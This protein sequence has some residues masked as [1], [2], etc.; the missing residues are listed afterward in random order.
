MEMLGLCN[1]LCGS[2]ELVETRYFAKDHDNPRRRG[3]RI[4]AF[5]GDQEFLDLLHNFRKDFLST[6]ALVE[7]FTSAEATGT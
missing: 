4:V 6:S 2:F 3:A 7:T 5:E 1:N